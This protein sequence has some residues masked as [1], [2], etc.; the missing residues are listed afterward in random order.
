MKKTIKTDEN[1]LIL[2]KD[3]EDMVDMAKVKY[4]RVVQNKDSTI[5]LKLYDKK[6]KLVK[7]FKFVAEESE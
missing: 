2:L 4:Y 7:P 5:T 6:K 1:G 3:L